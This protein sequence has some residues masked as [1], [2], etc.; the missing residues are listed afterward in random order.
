MSSPTL[1]K[2]AR[3]NPLYLEGTAGQ[4]V[5]RKLRWNTSESVTQPRGGYSDDSRRF[6]EARRAIGWRRLLQMAL[7]V[8]W[9]AVLTAALPH[10]QLPDPLQTVV[11]VM[12]WVG[13]SLA[14]LTLVI[15]AS[16][17]SFIEWV[18]RKDLVDVKADAIATLFPDL[19]EARRLTA[20][21]LAATVDGDG[22][23]PI[24]TAAR[25]LLDRVI[26]TC[27]AMYDAGFE[28]DEPAAPRSD[29][30]AA[31]MEALRRVAQVSLI[32]PADARQAAFEDLASTM[33][34]WQLR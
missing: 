27:I 34:A 4:A 28:E 3:R 11:S 24:R 8:A 7:R 16:T 26:A 9:F 30:I 29:R 18:D 14:V 31:D 20:V 32:G 6:G 17:Q 10:M 2:A 21:I 13:F 19:V 23:A 25:T 5:Y 12:V 22:S 15:S 1:T 33:A